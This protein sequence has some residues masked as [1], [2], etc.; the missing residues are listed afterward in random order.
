ADDS[1]DV[2]MT[3]HGARVEIHADGSV[4]AYTDATV[5]QHRANDGRDETPVI[6]AEL[7]PGDRMQDGTIYAGLSPD[8]G[9]EM[10][11]TPADATGTMKWKKAM[12]YAAGLDA[13]GRR[14]WRVPTKAEV[15]VLYETR[16]KGALKGTL[17]VT[18]S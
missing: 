5:R 12:D 7:K 9:K 16:D 2:A 3:A 17:N 10:Y 14:D 13:H 18:G 4:D 15:N 11:T 8:T 6:P 1:G